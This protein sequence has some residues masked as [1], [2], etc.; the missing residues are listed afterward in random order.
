MKK[1]LLGTVLV[2]TVSLLSGCFP[3]AYTSKEEKEQLAHAIAIARV[4]QKK[5]APSITLK[6][7]KFH[8]YD[9]MREGE[10]KL[11]LTDWVYGE[12]TDGGKYELYI[13]TDAN[14]LYSDKEWSKIESYGTK[15]A[16]Q[17]YGISESEMLADIWGSTELPFCEKDE[18]FGMLT[19]SNMLPA[20]DTVDKEYVKNV[21]FDERYHKTYRIYVGEDVDMDIFKKTDKTP[22]GNNVSLSVRQYSDVAFSDL[23]NHP[24]KRSTSNREGLLD[25]YYSDEEDEDISDDT[26]SGNE[27]TAEISDTDIVSDGLFASAFAEDEVE[28]NG[29]TFV[30]VKNRVYFRV[31]G[32]RS[33]ELTTLGVPSIDEVRADIPSTLM[34]YDLDKDETVEVCEVCGI[35]PLYATVDGLCLISYPDGFPSTTVIDEDG[36]INEHYID[37]QITG[38]SADGRSVKDSSTIS[39]SNKRGELCL[40]EGTYGDLMCVSPDGDKIVIVKDY[41]SEPGE[42][43]RYITTVENGACFKGDSA[44]F[45]ELGGQRCPEEDTGERL[46][47]NLTTVHYRMF[48]FD[49]EHIDKNGYPKSSVLTSLSSCGW[50]KGDIEY[51]RLIG[52]WE[53]YSNNVEGEYRLASEEPDGLKLMIRFNADGSATEYYRDPKTGSTKNERQLHKAEQE[54]SEYAPDYAYYYESDD[55]DP[56]QVGVMY[57]SHNRLCIYHLYHFDGGST[58]WYEVVYNKVK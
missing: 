29:G 23:K 39:F 3:K 12:Y 31:Y 14:K 25:E 41:L 48:R 19:L 49:D 46:A 26:A 9:A 20:T 54:D 44:F 55:E 22:L 5:Y 57:L 8:V 37:G 2:L 4:Y 47:Y 10:P 16:T 36:N 45:L 38:V 52:E 53:E 7:D 33:L 30:R 15:L 56:L 51:D 21:L 13:N 50:N 1:F 27:D 43:E 11:C 32:K 34:Y 40:S 17:L 6:E 42:D 58:A 18:A 35:G 24:E 28:N